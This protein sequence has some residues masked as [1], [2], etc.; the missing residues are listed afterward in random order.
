MMKESVLMK[1]ISG[2]FLVI[3]LLLTGCG[4]GSDPIFKDSKVSTDLIK[5]QELAAAKKK[6]EEE[7]KKKAE[8]AKKKEEEA[9]KK[10]EEEAKKTYDYYG[11]VKNIGFISGVNVFALDS[12]HKE[13]AHTTTDKK[14]TFRFNL[15][16][17]P[18]FIRVDSNGGLETL[19]EYASYITKCNAGI[20]HIF[21]ADAIIECQPI[22]LNKNNSDLNETKAK[23]LRSYLAHAYD[24]M[25]I[26][27]SVYNKEILKALSEADDINGIVTL[28]DTVS[29]LNSTQKKIVENI[30]RIVNESNTDT[31]TTAMLALD[32][33][34]KLDNNNTLKNGDNSVTT[35]LELNKKTLEE[36]IKK[37]PNSDIPTL[38]LRL[39]QKIESNELSGAMTLAQLEEKIKP[40]DVAKCTLSTSVKACFPHPE[41]L[42]FK[43]TYD[44][45]GV[46]VNDI[47]TLRTR[48]EK[49]KGISEFKVFDEYVE[50]SK[51]A[52]R[53][54]VNYQFN[55]ISDHKDNLFTTHFIPEID[56]TDIADK[57]FLAISI[58]EFFEDN[59]ESKTSEY[60][61]MAFSLDVNV[62]SDNNLTIFVPSNSEIFF[63]S[64]IKN[65]DNSGYDKIAVKLQ[66]GSNRSLA[67]SNGS[68]SIDPL[69]YFDQIFDR[70]NDNSK[71]TKMKN[72]IVKHSSNKDGIPGLFIKNL[73]L[74]DVSAKKN[75]VKN[76]REIS[77]LNFGLSSPVNP[78]KSSMPTNSKLKLVRV[79][80]YF[81]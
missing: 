3:F 73:A 44:K 70:M 40:A 74:V 65:S 36:Y 48:F 11:F 50:F 9:K 39:T 68:V 78:Y 77:S 2:L 31:I 16:N 61:T 34:I 35:W 21:K 60:L 20:D 54:N 75:F 42:I 63:Y 6:A 47:V 24:N 38:A 8:E 43:G 7:A 59:D 5:K 64:K 80:S 67:S 30:A 69:S 53:E 15:R 23:L 41:L 62:S 33:V 76:G 12:N 14:G 46:E 10:E 81:K 28:L 29:G 71:I 22:S 79:K 52:L 58:F 37:Y 4:S 51:I 32:I 45:S 26:L 19:S 13:I 1:T 55:L 25:G 27:N 17:A 56:K 49:T 72:F 57:K 66:N 18:S